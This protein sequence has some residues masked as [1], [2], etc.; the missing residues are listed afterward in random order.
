MAQQL[1]SPSF[2][3]EKRRHPSLDCEDD[4]DEHSPLFRP[5]PTESE[6]SYRQNPMSSTSI[7]SWRGFVPCLVIFLVTGLLIFSNRVQIRESSL[8]LK[9]GGTP[10]SAMS[11][12]LDGDIVPSGPPSHPAANHDSIKSHFRFPVPGQKPKLESR[13]PDPLPQQETATGTSSAFVQALGI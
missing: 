2:E 1:S 4:E 6:E 10:T 8:D 9:P 11:V 12:G 7:T 5:F 13:Y 3:T